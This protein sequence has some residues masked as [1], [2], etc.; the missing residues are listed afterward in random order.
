MGGTVSNTLKEGGTEKRGG[1]T[2][3]LKYIVIYIIPLFIHQTMRYVF[4]VKQCG[5]KKT[6]I[7]ALCCLMF[8]KFFFNHL[9]NAHCEGKFSKKHVQTS[10]S[11]C[12]ATL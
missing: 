2:K 6:E 10:T 7:L 4:K 3:I 5:V 9:K 8:N 12:E 11:L 1:Q